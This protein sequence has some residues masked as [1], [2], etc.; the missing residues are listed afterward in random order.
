MAKGPKLNEV[1][2]TFT[3]RDNLGIESATASIQADLCP[4]INTVTP[5]AFYWPFMVW[6]YYEYHVSYKTEKKTFTDFDKNFLKKNDYFM[7][8]ANL[9]AKNDQNNLVGKTRALENLADTSVTMY[10]YD[11]TYFKTTFGGMQYYNAGCLTMG[12]ITDE[13]GEGNL[14]SLARLTKEVGEPMALAFAK[15]IENTEYYKNYRLKSDVEVPYAVLEELGQVLKFN[16]DGF[17]E[18]KAL[19]KDALF[20]PKNNERLNNENLIKSSEYIK[21]MYSEYGV[22]NPNLYEMRRVLFDYFSPR[23]EAKPYDD[24]LAEIIN[25][26]EIVVGRQYLTMSVE[27]MW[28][29]M[30]WMLVDTITLNEWVERCVNTAEWNIDYDK[31]LS[32]LLPECNYSFEER[33]KMISTGSGA[34]RNYHTNIEIG[35]KI[36]LSLYNR[37]VN[38]DELN[39]NYLHEGDD[40]SISALIKLVDD[41]R[42]KPIIKFIQYIMVNWIVK[43]HEFVAREKLLQGRD[44]FYFERID[45][46]YVPAGHLSEPGFKGLRMLQLLQVMKDL[47][48]LEN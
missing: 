18:A 36:L 45:D 42:D 1:T 44:G 38:R 29:Y 21:F 14:F 13:D 30:L 19:L 33:E 46:L 7:V 8:M 15:V 25:N 9:I 32:T 48:M 20:T 11:R 43:K 34:S 47:D 17:D 35:L 23:G 28:K 12:F 16:L 41:F 40:V 2:K 37:F 5:R 22:K 39:I 6:N 24:S 27:L 4:V 26:W 10:P 31:P 3:T